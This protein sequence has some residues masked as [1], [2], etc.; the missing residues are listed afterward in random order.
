MC[1]INRATCTTQ[2]IHLTSDILIEMLYTLF[3]LYKSNLQLDACIAIE[4]ISIKADEELMTDVILV[5][6]YF[7]LK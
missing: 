5:G 3:Y 6:F 7:C 4:A 1:K 2:P